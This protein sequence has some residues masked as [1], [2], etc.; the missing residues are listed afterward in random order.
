MR[1]F[2]DG[3]K[4]GGPGCAALS[5]VTRGHGKVAVQFS[6]RKVKG[7]TI[8]LANA[9]TR[10]RCWKQ[11]YYSCQGKPRDQGTKYQLEVIAFKR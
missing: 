8:T 11:T 5:A 1:F 10:Y 4:R 7:V 6:S 3:G 2:G 9:S